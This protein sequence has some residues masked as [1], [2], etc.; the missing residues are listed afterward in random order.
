MPKKKGIIDWIIIAVISLLAI[1]VGGIGGRAVDVTLKEDGAVDVYA[2]V[3]EFDNAFSSPFETV[4]AIIENSDNPN[5]YAVIRSV[6]TERVLNMVL[7]DGEL[8][9]ILNRISTLSLI[10]TRF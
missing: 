2:A 8:R 7:Q 1:V 6:F 5:S 10:I 9:Q 3:T 4:K